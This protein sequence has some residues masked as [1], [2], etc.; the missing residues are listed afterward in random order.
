MGSLRKDGCVQGY[1]KVP[2][3][4]SKVYPVSCKECLKLQEQ[5]GGKLSIHTCICAQPATQM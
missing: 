4:S 3:A 1:Y 5:V 2:A